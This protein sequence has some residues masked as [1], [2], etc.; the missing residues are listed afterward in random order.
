VW[1]PVYGP[2]SLLSL[3][4]EQRVQ[5]PAHPIRSPGKSFFPFFPVL[6]C[7]IAFHKNVRCITQKIRVQQQTAHPIALLPAFLP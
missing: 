3:H 6:F 7:T 2:R 5:V 4:A 1:Q